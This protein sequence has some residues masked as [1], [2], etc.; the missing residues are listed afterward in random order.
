[1]QNPESQLIVSRF[2]EALSLLKDM[3]LIRGEQT[4]A[5]RYDI[6]R[7]NLWLLKQDFSRDIFQPCWLSYLV[8]DYG[9]SPVWLLLGTGD[10][11]QSKNTQN[12]QLTCK[13]LE[14]S[15]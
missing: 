11:L 10:F 13:S 4:F 1:M 12:V 2:F 15:L 8:R 9:V 3:K 5:N 14:L 7:R 6:N